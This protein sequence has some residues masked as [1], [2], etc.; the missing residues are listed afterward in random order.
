M[1]NHLWKIKFP[2]SSHLIPRMR[3][4]ERKEFPGCQRKLFENFFASRKR[5]KPIFLPK[6]KEKASVENAVQRKA[7]HLAKD[8]NYFGSYLNHHSPLKKNLFPFV[9]SPS[10]THPP[11]SHS[12]HHHVLLPILRAHAPLGI[13]NLIWAMAFI[14]KNLCVPTPHPSR[15]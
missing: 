6:K 3:H 9:C 4:R 5:N 8:E 1:S 14:K 10:W 12:Q 15:V 2:H 13:M 7:R 11:W